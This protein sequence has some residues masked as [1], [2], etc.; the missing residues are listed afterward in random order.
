MPDLT[1]VGV[2]V[3]GVDESAHGDAALR[4]ALE[5]AAHRGAVLR[6][7]IACRPPEM[8][9]YTYEILHVPNPKQVRVAAAAAV[10]RR[11]GEIR[12]S[13]PAVADVEVEVVAESGSPVSV[14]V[15]AARDAD[16]VVVGHRG[17]GALLS[18]LL[19]SVGLGVVL[20]APCPV[21]V[22]PAPVLVDDPDGAGRPVHG[23]LPLPLPVGPVA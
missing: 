23:A 20:N 11:V 15:D 14:L 7:V 4:Y 12:S 3:V 9:A 13:V 21:T 2:L 10:R 18:A 5:E 16:L 19:G 17:R 6:A 22:V 1:T 8:S